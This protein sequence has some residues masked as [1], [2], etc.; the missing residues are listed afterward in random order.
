MIRTPMPFA[1][2]TDSG[3]SRKFETQDPGFPEL[4]NQK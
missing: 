1:N 3:S 4:W 2:K